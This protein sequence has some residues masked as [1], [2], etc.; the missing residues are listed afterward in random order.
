MAKR[1]GFGKALAGGAA[2]IGS[3][4]DT[5]LKAAIQEQSQIRQNQFIST[6]Q[7]ELAELEDKLSRGRAIE[8][9]RF[10][11]T[12]AAFKDPD[13]AERAMQGGPTL[14]EVDLSRFVRTQP[15]RLGQ[16]LEDI[17]KGTTPQ[18]VAGP[19]QR[20]AIAT[21]R[22]INRPDITQLLE[23]AGSERAGNIEQ[24]EINKE[25]ILERIGPGGVR[26]RISR[27]GAT[28]MPTERSGG[29]EGQRKF[30]EF[31]AGEGSPAYALVKADAENRLE[32]LTRGEKVRTATDLARGQAQA[33]S[34]VR[35]SPETIAGEAER[36]R[37]IKEAETAGGAGGTQSERM[38]AASTTPMIAAAARA[39]DFEQKG[40]AIDPISLTKAS[41]PTGAW[42]LGMAENVP[43]VGGMFKVG[44]Q[45]AGY[46]QA[47][48]DFTNLIGKILSGVTV[49]PDE[50]GAY[51]STYFALTNDSTATRQQKFQARQVLVAAAT[52]SVGRSKR[53]VGNILGRALA[54]GS[55]PMD[56]LKIME[57]DPEINEGIADIISP[58][59][60][61]A[62]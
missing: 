21:A 53:E 51:L 33:A 35:L 54:Q 40:A 62:Q 28:F 6:R 11:L 43:L 27:M 37:A 19:A 26:G 60:P 22:G 44:D 18:T 52:A 34:D 17:N 4:I 25:N 31:Q 38:A 42:V 36:A 50:R 16:A 32:Q 55:L 12:E 41:S 59:L 10:N 7:K 61:G 5:Y 47:A 1:R 58:S 24:E 46:A 9:N 13:A 56:T 29:Q 45:S 20:Q 49:R 14:N 15:Q 2:S 30:E 39:I 23:G 3:L 57:F 8:A 48:V